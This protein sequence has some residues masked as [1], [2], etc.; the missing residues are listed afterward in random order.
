MPFRSTLPSRRWAGTLLVGLA[1]GCGEQRPAP[2]QPR[3]W[4]VLAE[5]ASSALMSVSGT[6]ADDVWMVGADAGQGPPVLHYDGVAWASLDPGVRANLWWV[7]ALPGGSVHMG[8][9][10][11]TVLA[12]RDGAFQRMD[13]PGL[14]RHTVYGVWASADDDVYAVGSVV[15]RDGFI[16]HFDGRAFTEVPLPLAALPRDE[17]LGSAGLLKVWGA[18]ADE[19][20]VVGDRGVVLQGNA[21]DGFSPIQ[22]S[23]D[24]QL[25]TVHGAAGQ[26]VM[27]GG[28]GNGLAVQVSAGRLHDIT[29]PGSSLLQGVSVSAAG[30]VWAVGL[31]GNIYNRDAAGG[32][33]YETL[34]ETPVQSLHAVWVDPT[35]DVWTVGGNV[36]VDDL[37][38]GVALH[39][40]ARSVLPPAPLPLPHP[41]APSPPA[42]APV[43][44]DPAPATSIARRWN[45]QLLGAIRR[46]VPRDMV[47]ARNLFHLSVAIWDAWAAYDEIADGYVLTERASAD[48]RE[49]ARREAISYAAYRVLERRFASAAGGALSQECFSAFMRSLGYDPLDLTSAGDTPR[50]LGNRIGRAVLEAFAVDGANEGADYADPAGAPEDNPPL[51]A[52]APGLVSNDPLRWQPNLIESAVTLNGIQLGSGIQRY[53]GS[54]WGGVTPFAL[55]RP[56]PD[57]PYLDIGQPP[58][59]VDEVLLRPVVD[60]IG[61]SGELGIEDGVRIDVS[62]GARGN[63]SLGADDGSGRPTNPVSGLPYEARVSLRGD[64]TRSLVAYWQNGPRSETPPGHWNVLAN[65]VSYDARFERRL[66]GSDSEV[67]DPLAWDAHLYLALNGALHDAAIAAWE[68]KRRYGT[69]RPISLVRYLASR[70]QRDDPELPAY[71]PGGL[72][73]VDGSIEVITAES[74]AP[75]E[76]HAGFGPNGPPLVF[77][78]WPG[79]PGDRERQASGVRWIRAERWVPFQRRSFVGPPFP[80]YVS[81]HSAFGRAA[82]TVLSRLSG[83]EFFPGGIGSAR[84]EPGALAVEAGPSEPVLLEWATYGDAADQAGQACIWAGINVS[85]DDLEGRRV[86]AR[87][88]EGAALRASGYFDGSARP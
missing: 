19:V 37:D 32:E 12:Y 30:A 51:Q 62:P 81:E 50:A 71:D 64:F 39:G 80:G 3:H 28:S 1:L 24:E 45:E 83:S 87:A 41:E 8:G 65:A 26:V 84:V 7:H 88:G 40:S 15:G 77:H 5:G 2:S 46:D 54:H 13:T 25:F 22:S 55:E 78:A 34:T 47:Q 66:F 36:L 58:T 35:G 17:R 10:N 76:R 4:Q 79:E 85:P 27:V 9:S 20:W 57:A 42:C 52:D 11:A 60:L 72:L 53:L 63:N 6:A 82:A 21:R 16:W 73:L 74:R 23:L 38:G 29:P 14:A 56:A 75:G 31:G 33:W 70:G 68:L 59:T 48:D 69:A 43:D 86:G 61:K 49:A 67:L 44:I 18:S